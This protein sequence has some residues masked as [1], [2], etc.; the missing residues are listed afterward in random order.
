MTAEHPIYAAARDWWYMG[1]QYGGPDPFR[2]KKAPPRAVPVPE[3]ELARWSD[4]GG[5]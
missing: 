4:E 3:A 5:A 2:L 1:F